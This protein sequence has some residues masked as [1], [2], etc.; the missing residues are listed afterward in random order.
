MKIS[1]N[2]KKTINHSYTK[3]TEHH[4][5]SVFYFYH[6]IADIPFDINASNRIKGLEI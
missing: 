3:K 4:F 5:R 6:K 2:F 1:E